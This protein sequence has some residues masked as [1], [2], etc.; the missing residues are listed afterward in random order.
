M[1]EFGQF[2]LCLAWLLALGSVVGGAVA[3]W[4]R[5]LRPSSL[6]TLR[7]ATIFIA[8]SLLLSL[9]ALGYAFVTNDYTVQYV[10]QYSNRDMPW[11]YKITAIWGG[12]DGSMLLWCITD[13]P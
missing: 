10:W 11:I 2:A 4:R 7:R 13:C 9:V 5:D 1:I 3:G 6:E 12:M 8:V